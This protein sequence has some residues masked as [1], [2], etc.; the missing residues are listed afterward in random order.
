L[1]DGS[2][3]FPQADFLE[4]LAGDQDEEHVEIPPDLVKEWTDTK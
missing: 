4:S 1:I 2:L 3:L